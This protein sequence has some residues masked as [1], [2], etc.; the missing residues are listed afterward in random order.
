MSRGI[1]IDHAIATQRPAAN[2]CV[3]LFPRR[4]SFRRPMV[5]SFIRSQGRTKELDMLFCARVISV[6]M[7]LIN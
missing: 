5:R 1:L 7:A 3:H 6:A 2:K 4:F